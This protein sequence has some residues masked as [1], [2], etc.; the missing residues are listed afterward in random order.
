MNNRLQPLISKW[1]KNLLPNFRRQSRVAAQWKNL[2]E[3]SGQIRSRKSPVSKKPQWLLRVLLFSM[4]W[5]ARRKAHNG[6]GDIRA[7]NEPKQMSWSYFLTQEQGRVCCQNP[8]ALPIEPT[9]VLLRRGQT[10]TRD[11]Q[12]SHSVPVQGCRR[13]PSRASCMAP[14]VWA[15]SSPYSAVVGDTGSRWAA[16]SWPLS[17]LGGHLPHRSFWVTTFVFKVCWA[18]QMHI[19]K[20]HQGRGCCAFGGISVQS[21]SPSRGAPSAPRHPCY[22]NDTPVTLLTPTVAVNSSSTLTFS[23]CTVTHGCPWCSV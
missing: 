22:G 6:R 2:F 23:S 5:V 18:P 16:E 3:L 9:E 13:E 20:D 4:L 21:H 15:L 10:R 11:R 8:L 19:L 14:P 17:C 12:F 1:L 7:G